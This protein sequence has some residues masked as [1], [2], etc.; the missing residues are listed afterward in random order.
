MA[1]T[2]YWQT[3]LPTT[4]SDVVNPLITQS[5]IFAGTFGHV[6]RLESNTG[7]VLAHNPRE[8]RAWST[9]TLAAPLLD[10]VIVVGIQSH[11]LGLN[12]DT[13]ATLWDTTL[14]N[15]TSYKTDVSLACSDDSIY[16]TSNGWIHRLALDTGAVVVS[17]GISTPAVDTWHRSQ[18]HLSL[19]VE[20]TNLLYTVNGMVHVIDPE[21]LEVKWSTTVP[22]SDEVI[23]VLAGASGVGYVASKGRVHRLRLADGVLTHHQDLT[24]TGEK[25]VRMALDIPSSRLYIGTNGYGVSLKLPELEI[26]YSTSLPDSGY[27]ITSVASGND[28]AYFANNGIVYA[29][30]TQGEVIAKNGLSG[31]GYH[32]TRLATSPIGVAEI[33][34]LAVG[35]N[36]Y[37]LGLT[38]PSNPV[39][40]D[41]SGVTYQVGMLPYILVCL[42]LRI[43]FAVASRS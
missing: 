33:P 35:I 30:N 16:A 24:V 4:F 22:D 25:E 13:L 5:G 20:M 11:V 23:S 6:V 40:L 19:A 3:G 27:S 39:P 2:T 29:L 17:K 7:K 1:L 12:P 31:R 41:H 32:E 8:G 10:T 37:A 14:P 18:E 34:L 38:I 42:I 9:P 28:V 43:S 26:I 36:G 21:T 15:P